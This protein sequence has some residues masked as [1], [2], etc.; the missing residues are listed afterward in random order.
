MLDDG[1]QLQGKQRSNSKLIE[2]LHGTA[3]GG[4]NALTGKVFVDDQAGGTASTDAG[5]TLV[6]AAAGLL[7]LGQLRFELRLPIHELIIT[8]AV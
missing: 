7:R 2:Q 3:A 6:A 1:L 8:L 4:S 5:L